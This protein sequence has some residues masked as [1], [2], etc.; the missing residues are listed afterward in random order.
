MG[1]DPDTPLS[2]VVLGAAVWAG[3]EPSPT[4]R[5]RAAHA[6][7]LWHRGGVGR[8]VTTGGIGR[9]PPSEAQVAAR[10]CR[11]LGVPDAVLRP[12]ERSRN[13]FEN[14][15]FARGLLPDPPGPVVLVSDRYHL[16]R[17]WLIARL[18]GLA[19]RTS[20]APR[21]ARS[22]AP[23]RALRLLREAFALAA[24]V[25]VTVWRMARLRRRQRRGA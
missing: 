22:P 1:N 13:T 17:A 15:A 20:A 4:L 25:P 7:A 23:V 11:D 10:I 21:G 18:M 24:V 2:V 5:R 16:P 12:E 19:A 8:I 3:G 9:H 6:A 14:L